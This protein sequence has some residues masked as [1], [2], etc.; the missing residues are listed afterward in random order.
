M[1]IFQKAQQYISRPFITFYT[2][3]WSALRRRFSMIPVRSLSTYS[4]TRKNELKSF[5]WTT[6]SSRTI[7]SWDSFFNNLISRMAVI[8]KPSR[9]RSRRTFFR[10]TVAFVSRHSPLKTWPNVPS[11]M[12][13]SNLKIIARLCY[14]RVGLKELVGSFRS[15]IIHLSIQI[16]RHEFIPKLNTLIIHN[17]IFYLEQYT[18]KFLEKRMHYLCIHFF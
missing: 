10:A 11:P 12:I 2:F 8:G 14:W 9:S 7:F 18:V 16:I 15:Q 4:N 6:Q 13:E 1:K 3:I 5:A 17:I